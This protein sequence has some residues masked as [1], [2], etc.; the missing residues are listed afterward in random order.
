MSRCGAATLA[1]KPPR[2][3]ER[4]PSSLD[5]AKGWIPGG[6]AAI[7]TRSCPLWVI[8]A[9]P[10][11]M[12][13]GPTRILPSCSRL[14]ASVV[15]RRAG[16]GQRQIPW[17]TLLV[18]RSG[19]GLVRGGNIAPR[20]IAFLCRRSQLTQAHLAPT[21]P[22]GAFLRKPQQTNRAILLRSDWASLARQA[23]PPGETQR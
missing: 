19:R 3:V 11:Q 12:A 15:L 23:W 7:L 10:A 14:K 13:R 6:K 5:M 18:E 9:L 22:V 17:L 4:R 21:R 2:R 16:G 20:R 1:N 8:A